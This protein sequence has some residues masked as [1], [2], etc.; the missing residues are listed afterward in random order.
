[1][2]SSPFFLLLTSLNADSIECA[3][4]ILMNTPKQQ[5]PYTRTVPCT[6]L[7][8]FRNKKKLVRRESW[9]SGRHRGKQ[10][11]NNS[12]LQLKVKVRKYQFLCSKLLPHF[13][14]KKKTSTSQSQIILH[15][16]CQSLVFLVAT[17]ILQPFKKF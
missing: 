15:V 5:P 1:M 17:P 9:C 10:I 16:H 2:V 4:A 7:S 3:S 8:P 6:F 14:L 12:H 13:F 11:C